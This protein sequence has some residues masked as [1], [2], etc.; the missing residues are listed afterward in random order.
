MSMRRISGVGYFTTFFTCI[1][2]VLMVT[3]TATVGKM[4]AKG[5]I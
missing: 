4:I 2:V 3:T 1:V 5:S